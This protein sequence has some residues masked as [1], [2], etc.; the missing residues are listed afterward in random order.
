[1]NTGNAKWTAGDYTGGSPMNGTPADKLA[2]LM[3]PQQTP[4]GMDSFLVL[5]M[6]FHAGSAHHEPSM[7]IAPRFVL[8]VLD[9][10]RGGWPVSLEQSPLRAEWQSDVPEEVI[11]A[12][13]KNFGNRGIEEV[14]T[15]LEPI[16]PYRFRSAENK[17]MSMGRF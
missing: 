14:R 2:R 8:A 11:A 16:H 12:W 10:Q 3:H 7:Y 5:W 15:V 4:E 6:L 17:A 1:M 13:R 9:L